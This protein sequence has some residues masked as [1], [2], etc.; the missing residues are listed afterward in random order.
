MAMPYYCFP[1]QLQGLQLSSSPF[2][3]NQD[4]MNADFS[5]RL[6]LKKHCRERERERAGGIRRYIRAE[7][8][9]YWPIMAPMEP[10][11]TMLFPSFQRD[12]MVSY[13]SP[14]VYLK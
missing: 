10:A 14:L 1:T 8:E 3:F 6:F 12:P 9:K 7:N 5:L 11:S 4:Y 2:E 13:P